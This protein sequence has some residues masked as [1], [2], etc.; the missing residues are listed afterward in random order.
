MKVCSLAKVMEAVSSR[1]QVQPLEQG[2][3]GPAEPQ[4]TALRRIT[5]GKTIT[6]NPRVS[7]MGLPTDT[8]P[9]LLP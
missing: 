3:K 1:L 8:V 6:G 2:L 5:K 4:C 7:R 9:L